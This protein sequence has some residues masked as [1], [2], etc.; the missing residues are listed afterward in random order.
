MRDWI[1]SDQSWPRNGEQGIPEERKLL[2]GLLCLR[3]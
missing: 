1:R 2:E 3:L